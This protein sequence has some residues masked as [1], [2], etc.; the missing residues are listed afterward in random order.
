MKI[1]LYYF[2]SLKERLG[3]E[4]EILEIESQSTPDEILGKLIPN[5][6][7]KDKI[8]RYLRVAINQE[9]ANMTTPLNEGD[10]VVFIPP[11]AGG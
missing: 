1:S 10:E 6:Q 4:K 5:S 9:Y 3:K 8:Q 7:E 2:A 11:V